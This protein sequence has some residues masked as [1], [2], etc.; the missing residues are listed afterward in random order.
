MIVAFDPSG[1]W[2]EGKGTTG[3]CIAW[4]RGEL[5]RVDEIQA[6]KF[7]TPEEYWNA[8]IKLLE[9]ILETTGDLE[10]VME[11]FRLYAHKKDQQ[12][13]SMF[14]TPMLIG[15]IRHWC[16]CNGVPLKIQY[17]VEVKNR[18]SDEILLRNGYITKK[19]NFRYFKNQVLNNHKTDAIRHALH[20][21]TFTREK[22]L[23]EL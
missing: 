6:V 1:N 18:W 2:H 16:W 12:T 14:E 20:Y 7:K 23:K 21:L 22:H 11:G 9:N 17:A 8:H 15:I 10:V 13:N 4:S 3:V 19:G 5:F